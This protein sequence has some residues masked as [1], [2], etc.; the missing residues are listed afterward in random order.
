[1]QINIAKRRKCGKM[2]E[3]CKIPVEL[4]GDLC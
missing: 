4:S 3:N 2:R 1:M